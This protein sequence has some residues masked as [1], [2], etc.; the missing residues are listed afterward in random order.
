MLLL[1][2]TTVVF[3]AEPLTSEAVA[4]GQLRRTRVGQV[5]DQTREGRYAASDQLPHGRR[6]GRLRRARIP[7]ANCGSSS[8]ARKPIA[9]AVVFDP[10]PSADS[11]TKWST[12]LRSGLRPT[13]G[14]HASPRRQG[15]SD[16]HRAS[17]PRPSASLRLPV[18]GTLESFYQSSHEAFRNSTASILLL[19]DEL[20]NR[21]GGGG[22]RRTSSIIQD[23]R[24][25]T[26]NHARHDR[27]HQ[28][29]LCQPISPFDLPGSIRLINRRSS[30]RN[31]FPWARRPRT[32]SR[33]E[34]S[35]FRGPPRSHRGRAP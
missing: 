29:A 27:F 9:H 4:D 1:Q 18:S 6:D 21:S 14:C 16:P 17:G 12:K 34:P 20:R 30:P 19:H 8:I 24:Q 26:M 33:I 31:K 13:S 23:F 7:P 35:L 22:R 10:I 2:I 15:L 11:S 32:R 5:S 28:S 3:V 25:A